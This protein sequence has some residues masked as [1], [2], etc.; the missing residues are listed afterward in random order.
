[1]LRIAQL[2]SIPF[3]ASRANDEK[4]SSIYELRMARLEKPTVRLHYIPEWASKRRLKQADIAREINAD[5]SN[6]SRWF[7]GAL[8]SEDN[9]LRLAA[10]FACDEPA[11]LF[12]HPDHDWM[13][14]LLRGRSQEEQRRIKET[15][16]ATI[17]AAFP[18]RA[19]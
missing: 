5:K 18:R 17:Q 11:D 10:L 13:W 15:I 8:P 9:I 14:G 19:A 7:N 2:L 12:R 6:V 1:V 3:V 16:E 4:R